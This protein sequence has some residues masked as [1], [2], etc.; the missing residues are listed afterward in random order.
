[1]RKLC[2]VPVVFSL[3]LFSCG[4]DKKDTPRPATV[5]NFDVAEKNPATIPVVPIVPLVPISNGYS[6]DPTLYSRS[7]ASVPHGVECIDALTNAGFP[8]AA[9]INLANY[10]AVSSSSAN[11]IIN[12]YQYSQE[13]VMTVID[14]SSYSS[15][16]DLRLMNA[17]AYYCLYSSKAVNSSV[18]V[19][20]LCNS[21]MVTL[22][23]STTQSPLPSFK[24]FLFPFFNRTV[25]TEGTLINGNGY[26]E[27]PCIQQNKSL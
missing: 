22:F 21:K 19:Q 16:V 1:M 3:F 23:T 9:A 13:T 7:V 27:L 11:V 2:C 10:K 5:S 20:R 12:D 8:E 14:L 26:I 24:S 25:N 17:N 18:V 4:D 15:G 6:I